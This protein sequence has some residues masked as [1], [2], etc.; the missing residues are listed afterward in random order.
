MKTVNVLTFNIINHRLFQLVVLPE[1]NVGSGLTFRGPFS[2]SSPSS[3]L[4][5]SFSRTS[6]LPQHLQLLSAEKEW[7]HRA[8]IQGPVRTSYFSN[9]SV[10]SNGSDL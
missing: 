9:F 7:M 8:S 5:V 2:Q 10:A 6:S 3:S 4:P 1:H